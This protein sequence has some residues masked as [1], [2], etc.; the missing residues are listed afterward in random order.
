MTQVSIETPSITTDRLV[1][2]PFR[3]SDAA[4]LFL[5]H[6]NAEVLRYWDSPPWTSPE[7]AQTFLQ[8]VAHMSS[9]GSGVRVSRTVRLIHRT[10]DDFVGSSSCWST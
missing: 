8:R 9:D 4:S 5:L 3:A 2:R 7:R 1:L 10:F 6:S